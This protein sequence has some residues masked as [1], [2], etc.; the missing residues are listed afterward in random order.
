M[1]TPTPHRRLRRWLITGVLMLAGLQQGAAAEALDEAAAEPTLVIIG[2]SYARGWTVDRLAGMRVLNRGVGGEQSHEVLARFERDALALGPDAVLI[3]GYINDIHN[4]PRDDP[5]GVRQR[6]RA[7]IEAMV[8]ASRER[9]IRPILTTELTVRGDSGWISEA[10]HLVG[11]LLGRESYQDRVNQQ[12]LQLNDWLRAYA[13]REGI[14]L[15]DAQPVL[16]DESGVRKRD[17]A[18][19]DGSHLTPA[20]YAELTR[21]AEREL[22]QR[23]GE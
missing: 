3:W 8:N 21:Y 16:S 12:V 15:L 5:D 20:A 11:R 17:F 19:E 22:A 10:K 1:S 13:Q 6:A 18:K 9:G 2:A 4:G 14:V 23:L 7:S